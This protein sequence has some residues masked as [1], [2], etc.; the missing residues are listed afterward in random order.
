M[1][2]TGRDDCGMSGVYGE[3]PH[4]YSIF[5]FCTRVRGGG[6]GALKKDAQ[7]NGV[8]AMGEAGAPISDP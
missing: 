5:I 3:L 2:S 7:P 6:G 4:L 8:L 1:L